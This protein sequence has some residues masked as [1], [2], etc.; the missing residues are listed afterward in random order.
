M[1]KKNITIILIIFIMVM[2]FVLI[3]FF[4]TQKT[5]LSNSIN[6]VQNLPLNNLS[7]T[8]PIVSEITTKTSS[9][10]IVNFSFKPSV[11]NINKGDTVIWT[12]NDSAPHQILGDNLNGQIINKGQTF[13]QI[14][15]ETGTVNYYC[16]IH[17]SM[18]GIIVVK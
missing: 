1:N 18:K 14:F 2:G 5:N 16:A 10:S 8:T 12:N 6:S 15:T 4:E 3:Y 17:P 7:T 11:L 13:T 9:I